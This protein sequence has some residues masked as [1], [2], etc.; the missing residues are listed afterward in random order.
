MSISQLLQ[1]DFSDV[2]FAEKHSIATITPSSDGGFAEYLAS[3]LDGGD[4]SRRYEHEVADKEPSAGGSY[5][6]AAAKP[7]KQTTPDVISAPT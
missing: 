4:R 3:I 1:A 6:A 2:R 7:Y 5:V